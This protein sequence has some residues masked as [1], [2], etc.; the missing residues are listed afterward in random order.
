M[1][2]ILYKSETRGHENHGWLD[3]KHTFS[4]ANY[5][6]PNRIHFGALRVFNDDTI[7][8]AKGFGT[9]P[10]DNMEIITIPL[11]GSLRHKDSLGHSSVIQ[12]G[13]IQVMSAGTGVLHS[14][15][16]AEHNRSVNLFQIW[17][18]PNKKN[19]TP[20][21]QEK[22]LKYLNR[23]NV[24]HQ[25]VSP[26]PSDDELWI[27][28]DAWFSI[29]AFDKN[30]TVD[31]QFKS[32][33]SGIFAIAVEGAFNIEGIELNRRDA[34]GIHETDNIQIKALTESSQLLLIEVPMQI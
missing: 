25:V 24:L 4:F 27:H 28:Q 7:D 34:I 2:T 32:E 1:K 18:F 8:G 17:I 26:T 11:K 29:G 33:N 19:V 9:H 13:D 12:A 15:Y 22:N 6:D 31:Y 16:N 5:Y 30:A 21:Y 14:E 23:K 3:A 20:R 10:H